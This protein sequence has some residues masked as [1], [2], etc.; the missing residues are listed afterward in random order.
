[1]DT[2]DETTFYRLPNIILTYNNAVYWYTEEDSVEG[3]LRGLNDSW[4]EL[5]GTTSPLTVCRLQRP[6]P[7][8]RPLDLIPKSLPLW[9]P[10]TRVKTLSG[11]FTHDYTVPTWIIFV[12]PVDRPNDDCLVI[13][14][15]LEGL[16]LDDN[17][18][19]SAI[20][21]PQHLWAWAAC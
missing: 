12:G 9:L 6:M 2:T 11:V 10:S 20:C 7:H 21:K 4:N 18:L 15:D 8:S 13:L 14:K 3:T 5:C 17:D 16:G 19:I 1:M